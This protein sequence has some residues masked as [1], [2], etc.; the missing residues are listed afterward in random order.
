MNK[1]KRDILPVW[2]PVGVSTNRLSQIVGEHFNTLSSHTGTL[3][4]L[5]EGV[6]IILLG[7]ARLKKYEYTHWPKTYVFEIVFGLATDSYDAMGFV[8]AKNGKYPSE[9]ECEE[10][11]SKFIG[12][13]SQK[14]PIYSAV[15]VKGRKLF[16]WG[17]SGEKPS[18][19]PIKKGEIF[20]LKLLD[21]RKIGEKTVVENILSRLRKIKGNFR[22][23]PIISQWEKLR[24]APAKWV[25][26]K[27]EVKMTKGL[28]VRS[29][30]QDICRRLK[31]KGFTYS[32]K[33]TKN[34]I[35]GRKDCTTV[36]KLFGTRKNFHDLVTGIKS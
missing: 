2:Q 35:Y 19:I 14:V 16:E 32:I 36:E 20:L 9:K 25:V 26:A 5:A 8:K 23:E 29:L 17:H 12:Q 3:D 33:R 28:Y 31:C 15:K 22:Q 6:V 30:S 34:G 11:C 24:N 4:P 1:A 27:F 7:D 18:E 10:V 13:Y 21:Y